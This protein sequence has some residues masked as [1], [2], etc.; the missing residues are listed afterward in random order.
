MSKEVSDK[1]EG[2]IVGVEKNGYFV[3]LDIG[4]QIFAYPSGNIRRH[5]I[6]IVTNDRVMVEVSAYDT[7]KGRITRRLT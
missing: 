1:Y 6:G 7:S 2:V 4:I 5:K 3:K